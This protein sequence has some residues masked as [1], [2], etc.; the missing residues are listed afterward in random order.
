MFDETLCHFT[1]FNFTEFPA[2]LV[3]GACNC[4]QPVHLHPNPTGIFILF[5]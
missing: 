3:N 2:F 4:G 5:S 1:I